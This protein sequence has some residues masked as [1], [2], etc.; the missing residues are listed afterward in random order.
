MDGN[1]ILKMQKAGDLFP[2][3]ADKCKQ[4][5]KELVKEWHPDNSTKKNANDVFQHINKLY[6]EALEMITKGKWEKTNFVTLVTSSGKKIEISFSAHSKFELGE[7][8]VCSKHVIYII[9]K[10]KE[11]YYKNAIERIKSIKYADK[12]MES[13]LSIFMPTIHNAYE[14][15]DGRHCLILKKTPDVYPLRNVLEYFKGK[16]PPKHTAWM[17][18]RLS[19][20]AC[21]LGYNNIVHNGINI[22]NC[23]VSP[24]FHSIM[25]LG[26]WWYSVPVGEKMIGI[27]KENY[28]VIPIVEKN[29]K[30]ASYVTDLESIKMVGRKLLGHNI[31]RTLLNDNEI[32]SAY[33]NFLIEG[34]SDD[35]VK[36]FKKWDKSLNDAYGKREFIKLELKKE[37]VYKR[38]E[39]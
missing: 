1:K 14:L 25:L 8:Y 16:V 27:T 22:D 38:K 28:D 26:G 18:S 6:S 24:E 23:Y 4:K 9:D 12:N 21:I 33:R 5:Y 37:D 39:I 35:A 11:K 7:T 17:I 20:I 10:D 13:K 34:A 31:I 2:N 19:N 32:P 30:V 3:D 36:E 15:D 29:K